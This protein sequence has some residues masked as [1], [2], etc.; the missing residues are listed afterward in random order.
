AV[1][2]SGRGRR[3][4]EWFSPR[5]GL[6]CSIVLRPRSTPERFGLLSVMAALAV[7][8][9]LAE[10]A[11]F[12]C[13]IKWPN[14]L[15]LEGRKVGGILVESALDGAGERFAVVGIGI[16]SV[17][18]EFPASLDNT[19]GSLHRFS[20]GA[21]SNRDLLNGI[22]GEV[23]AGCASLESAA[24]R[25]GILGEYRGCSLTLGRAVTV[26]APGGAFPARALDLT[27]G[28]ELLV[29]TEQGEKIVIRS[30]EVSLGQCC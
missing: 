16:N 29:E 9:A 24:G 8:R 23:H 17:V 19:A 13:G 7:R 6:W 28:G 15:L 25:A 21:V 22:L 3:G 14:D 12:E 20:R 30:G 18:E 2:T 27:P 10:A 11:G 26:Q 5:G 1:Q 4:R